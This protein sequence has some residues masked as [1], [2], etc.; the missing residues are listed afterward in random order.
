MAVNKLCFTQYNADLQVEMNHLNL[1]M[2]VSCNL[3]LGNITAL[4]QPM[5]YY[6]YYSYYTVTSTTLISCFYP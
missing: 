6:N 2:L 5:I 4:I 1:E 3:T